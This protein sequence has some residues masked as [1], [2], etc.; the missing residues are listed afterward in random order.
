[1]LWFYSGKESKRI[2][3][4]VIGLLIGENGAV[5]VS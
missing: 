4:T 3:G 1:M 2:A 5:V